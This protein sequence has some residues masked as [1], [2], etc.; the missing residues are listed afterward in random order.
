MKIKFCGAAQ[1]V[2]G[3][4]HL[5]ELDNDG[6]PKFIT[7]SNILTGNEIATLASLTAFPAIGETTLTEEELKNLSESEKHHL[8]SSMIKE[9]RVKDALYI[10]IR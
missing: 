1:Y 10:L 7:E 9:R 3:S 4:S 8:A 6:L 5:I 2:T